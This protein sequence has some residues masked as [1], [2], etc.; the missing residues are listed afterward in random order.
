MIA[1]NQ[2]LPGLESI[3]SG[4]MYGGQPSGALAG[5]LMPLMR[6]LSGQ[7]DS[8]QTG[9]TPFMWRTLSALSHNSGIGNQADGNPPSPATG[10]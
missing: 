1:P 10:R 6:G 8:T 4:L 9:F 7:L 3:I 2:P 5:A